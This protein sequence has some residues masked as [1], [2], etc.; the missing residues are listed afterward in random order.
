MSPFPTA[1]PAGN[2]IDQSPASAAEPTR[3]AAAA[4]LRDSEPR[5][6]RIAAAVCCSAWFAKA[7]LFILAWRFVSPCDAGATPP[8]Q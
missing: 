2:A 7:L 5:E 3:S 4:A 1:D 8:I 6:T